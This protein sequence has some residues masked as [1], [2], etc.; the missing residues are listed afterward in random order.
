MTDRPVF[1]PN[2][3]LLVGAD[4]K[5]GWNQPDRRRRGFHNAHR[6]FRRSITCRAPHCL[7]L[8]LDEEPELAARAEVHRLTTAR[9]EF[10]ALVIAQN[11]RILLSRHAKDFPSDQPH[12]IQS[13]SK[14]MM[15]LLAGRLIGDGLLD[16]T[17][18]VEH[19]LPDIGSGF[20]GACVQDVLDM[21][22]INHY[23]EDYE[24]PLADCYGEEIAMGWRLPARDQDEPTLKEFVCSITGDDLGNPGQEIRYSSANTDLM[25]LICDRLL[26][27][28]MPEMLEQIV[29][30]AG[31][32]HALHMSVSKD[33]MPAFS[34][35][36]CLSATDL[37][38]FGLLLARVFKTNAD[39][40]FANADFTRA[41]R[42]RQTRHLPPPRAH[43]RYA[44]HLMT[45]GR[46]IGHA[47]YGGQ[48]LMVD[49][50]SGMV[51]AYLSV[52]EN[53][54]GYDVDYIAETIACLDALLPP[55][56]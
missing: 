30:D 3:D 44:D 5:Q 21:N 28:A 48:F 41:A 46:W 11:N 45:N 31:I 14:L 10:S 18:L 15:H 42:H 29:S 36:G 1:H 17:R 26:P 8:T 51:C 9:P 24:N 4:H 7:D 53:A 54:S 33:G 37:A 43:I 13:I 19:Y 32:E 55:L 47:G 16:P 34:G 6:M 25:T 50:E 20:R 49:T 35:G 40:G 27:G 52:L 56:G 38:R 23:S 2:R 39:G 22:V 12:S